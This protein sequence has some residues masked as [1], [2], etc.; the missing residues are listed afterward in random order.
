MAERQSSGVS[1]GK[2]HTPVRLAA[3]IATILS[4]LAAPIG[5]IID[6]EFDGEDHP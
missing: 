4:L 6:G 1:A 3:L 2:V 5:A